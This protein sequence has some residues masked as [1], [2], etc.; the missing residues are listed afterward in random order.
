[1]TVV[2]TGASGFL[3]GHLVRALLQRGHRVRTPIPCERERALLDGLDV[4]V[5]LAD[6]RSPDSVR[7]AISGAEIVFHLAAHFANQ[8]SVDNP[9]KDL[10]VNGVGI[11]KVLQYAQLVDAKRFVYSSSGC[12]VYGLDSKMPFE[13]MSFARFISGGS[14]HFWEEPTNLPRNSP[15]A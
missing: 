4:D 2:V 1:M 10:M 6:V 14:L 12:G 3:G 13:E 7:D 5:V 8:N 9:E 11:L 15:R